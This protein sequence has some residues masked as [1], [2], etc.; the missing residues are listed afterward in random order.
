MQSKHVSTEQSGEVW[1][2]TNWCRPRRQKVIDLS[3]QIHFLNNDLFKQPDFINCEKDSSMQS[4]L[5]L[6]ILQVLQCFCNSSSIASLRSNTRDQTLEGSVWVCTAPDNW[7]LVIT[8][9][10]TSP[11]WR[12]NFKNCFLVSQAVMHQAKKTAGCFAFFFFKKKVLFHSY[13]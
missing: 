6:P 3:F 9:W 2:V 10:K 8:I 11:S 1:M 7:Q 12:K 4:F 5:M 13:A